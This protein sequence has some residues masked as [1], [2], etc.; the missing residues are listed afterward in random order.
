MIPILG[1]GGKGVVL[2]F[3]ACNSIPER[4]KKTICAFS[5]ASFGQ[6]MAKVVEAGQLHLIS[7]KMVIGCV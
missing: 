5:G 4:K 2:L 6:S 7:H 1:F 3:Y